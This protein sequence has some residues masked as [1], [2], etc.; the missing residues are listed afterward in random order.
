[1][2]R[3]QRRQWDPKARDELG[4]A[5]E[6]D[7]EQLGQREALDLRTACVEGREPGPISLT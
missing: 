1:M 6:G 4:Q 2:G 3:H 7:G 5:E